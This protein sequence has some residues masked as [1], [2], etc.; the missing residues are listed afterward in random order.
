M[1]IS[2]VEQFECPYC[3]CIVDRVLSAENTCCDETFEKMIDAIFSDVYS[4][5]VT[6]TSS[7]T[8]GTILNTG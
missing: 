4:P 1:D 3:R 6:L 2:Q 8:V 5:Q 7:R